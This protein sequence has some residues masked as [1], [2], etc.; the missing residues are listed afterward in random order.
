MLKLLDRLCTALAVVAGGL[1][2]F[3]TFSICYSI[4]T[5]A[6]GVSS[7]IWVVQSSEYSMLWMAFLGTAWLLIK[8]KHISI[9][10]VTSRLSERNKRRFRLLHNGVGFLVCAGFTYYC[11]LSTWDQFV[12]KI[13]DIQAVSV[14]RAYVIF[15]IPLG[16]LLLS[17]QFIRRFVAELRQSK[18]LAKDG[19]HRTG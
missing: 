9:Q 15:V 7:P 13:I 8:D 16:F 11:S 18:N 3:M 19:Q 10:I 17:L 4:L 1:L 14:P 2:L 6:L 12:R 5:R